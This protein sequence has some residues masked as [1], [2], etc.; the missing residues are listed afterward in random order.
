[1]DSKIMV[2]LFLH[3]HRTIFL[4]YYA[5]LYWP[6]GANTKIERV[7]KFRYNIKPATC[8]YASCAEIETVIKLFA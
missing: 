7:L 3:E 2:K 8:H 5:N 4:I 6:S 1:M